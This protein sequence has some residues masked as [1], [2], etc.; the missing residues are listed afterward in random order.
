MGLRIFE[1]TFFGPSAKPRKQETEKFYE[2]D[3]EKTIEL[4]SV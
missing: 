3:K 2:D 1:E 4:Y